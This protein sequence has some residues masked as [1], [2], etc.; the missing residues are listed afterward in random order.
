MSRGKSTC[1]IL[2]EI[3]RQIA[4]ANDI[5]FIT[6]ECRYQ[7]DCPGTCPKC[8]AEVRYLEEHLERRRTAGKTIALA[9]ISAGMLA[10]SSLQAQEPEKNSAD[11]TITPQEVIA[12]SVKRYLKI[13][14]F[15]YIEDSAFISRKDST[16]QVLEEERKREVE[17]YGEWEPAEGLMDEY[18]RMRPVQDSRGYFRAIFIEPYINENIRYPEGVDDLEGDIEIQFTV[19]QQGKIQNIQLKKGLH[20]LLDKEVLRMMKE[21][22]D[23]FPALMKGVE[24]EST[25]SMTLRLETE[26][27]AIVA[28]RKDQ[29]VKGTV[30]DESGNPLI[31]ASITEKGTKNETLSDSSG[32]FKLKVPKNATLTVCFVGME[33]QE[34]QARKDTPLDIVLRQDRQLMGE[35]PV[36]ESC[37]PGVIETMPEFPGGIH[38]LTEHL[39]TRIRYPEGVQEMEGRVIVQVTIDEDGYVKAPLIVKGLHPLLD[40]EALRVVS[41]LPRWKPGLIRGKPARMKYTIPVFFKKKETAYGN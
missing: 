29:L 10:T 11:K 38:G 3:R 2:K 4:E 7:G 33:T 8:E 14:D 5:E 18:P 21:M 34:V 26:G 41:G 16:I 37:L 32:A 13:T 28:E 1:R 27:T 6:S 30:K 20:P 39:A 23:W 35:V 17:K 36:E 25:V 12:A 9:G 15:H 24:I 31:C 40:K 19:T 22:P